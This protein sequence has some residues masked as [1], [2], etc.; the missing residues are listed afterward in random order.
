MQI[1]KE[2]LIDDLYSVYQN[3]Q[4]NDI[5]YTLKNPRGFR[6]PRVCDILYC[7]VLLHVPRLANLP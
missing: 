1:L 3:M 6:L 5:C 7:S 2:Q 4:L